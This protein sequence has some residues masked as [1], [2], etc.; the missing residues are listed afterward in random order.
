M[1]SLMKE[2]DKEKL[3]ATKYDV[4][5]ATPNVSPLGRPRGLNS[6]NRNI[7]MLQVSCRDL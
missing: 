5:L 4:S 2:A 3:R 7:E 1:N 6:W